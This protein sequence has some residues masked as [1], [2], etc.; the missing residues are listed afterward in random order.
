MKFYIANSKKYYMTI[1]K[2]KKLTAIY[3]DNFAVNFLKNGI[4]YSNKK[5]CSLY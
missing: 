4:F 3:F 5:K 2:D 1:I